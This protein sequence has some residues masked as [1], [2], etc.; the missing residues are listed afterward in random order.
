MTNNNRGSL[1]AGAAK[2]DITPHDLTGLTNLWRQPFEGVHDPIYIRALVVDNGI[3]C[4]AIVTA[5]LV[6]FGDTIEVRKQIEKET[7]IPTAHII[8]TASHDHNAPRVGGVTPGATAQKGG[9]ATEQY[10]AMVYGCILDVVRQAQAAL[11]PARVGT[12]K[13][14]ADVNTNRD[15]FTDDGWMMGANPDG[16]SEKTVWV[17][18]FE[19]ISGELIA[20]LMNYAVHSVVLG[21]NNTLVTGDLAGATERY[22]EQYYDDKVIAL[23]T[24]GAAGDQNPKFMS[25]HEN[26]PQFSD[27]IPGF[28]LM[29]TLGQLLG[30]EVVR[31]VGQIERMNSDVRIDADER[32][33]SCL[34]RIPPRDANRKGME[35]KKVDSLD[36]RLGL[37]LIDYI[38]LTWVSGEVV[39]NIYRHLKKE[40]PFSNT[41]MITIANDRVGYIV[42]DAGYDT[43]TFASTASPLQRGHAEPAIVNGLVEMMKKY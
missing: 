9:P 30:E 29:D 42:D 10:S 11:Q 24:L 22:V 3:N 38:A 32:L 31:V 1:L 17:V 40:S 36:I 34:A 13:G 20:I 18:K 19:T 39:T 14:T 15:V 33:V 8:I 21:A 6:E 37:I 12:G 4:A 23:W 26:P 7:G 35:V 41:I 2:I 28:Q 16:P 43:P 25:Y 5:D 27:R